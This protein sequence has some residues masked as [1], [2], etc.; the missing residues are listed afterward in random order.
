MKNVSF[1][2]RF[3]SICPS[4]LDQLA[5][6][7]EGTFYIGGWGKDRSPAQTACI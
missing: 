6:S 5:K 3:F 7:A 2:K 1:G 4:V